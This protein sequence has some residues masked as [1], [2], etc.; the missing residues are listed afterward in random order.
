VLR[1]ANRC[2]QTLSCQTAQQSRFRRASYQPVCV[3]TK[4][5]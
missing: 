1:A 5:L 4:E 3:M 2:L